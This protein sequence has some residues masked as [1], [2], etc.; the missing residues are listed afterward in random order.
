MPPIVTFIHSSVSKA[1][2]EVTIHSPVSSD[3]EKSSGLLTAIAVTLPLRS[4]AVRISLRATLLSP[5]RT[6]AFAS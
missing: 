4:S 2:C 1:S 3:A 6:N 5:G